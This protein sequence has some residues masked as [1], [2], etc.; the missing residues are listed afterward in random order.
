MASIIAGPNAVAPSSLRE[1]D[2]ERRKGYKKTRSPQIPQRA[3]EVF[4]RFMNR[5][6]QRILHPKVMSHQRRVSGKRTSEG[7][8]STKKK[9][10]QIEKSLEVVELIPCDCDRRLQRVTINPLQRE[11]NLLKSNLAAIS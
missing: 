11:G 5:P 2:D 4:T 8:L 1:K 10:P 7:K 3:N 9:I 6:R